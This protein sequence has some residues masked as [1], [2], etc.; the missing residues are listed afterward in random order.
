MNL[1]ITIFIDD[2]CIYALLLFFLNFKEKYRYLF[3][4]LGFENTYYLFTKWKIR[5]K[6]DATTW[7]NDHVYKFAK[8]WNAKRIFPMSSVD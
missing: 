7:E 2:I 8:M 4:L 3:K 1:P 6:D 5:G